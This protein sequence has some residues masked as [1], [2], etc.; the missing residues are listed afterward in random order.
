MHDEAE[1]RPTPATPEAILASTDLD[2]E[3]KIARL[4][5]LA[6]DARELEVAKDEGMGGGEQLDLSRIVR[7]LRQLGVEDTD[8]D[9]KQ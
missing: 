6:Y 2:R 1:G 8:T 7:A 5:E 9:H 4:R 3:Q